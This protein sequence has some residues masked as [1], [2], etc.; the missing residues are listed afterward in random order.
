LADLLELDNGDVLITISDGEPDTTDDSGPA[1]FYAN[2]AERMSPSDL[3]MI[4]WDILEAIEDDDAS[5]SEWL[6]E[7]AKAVEWLGTKLPKQG[8]GKGSRRSRSF[9]TVLLE[10]VLRAHATAYGE[11]LPADGPVKVRDDSEGDLGIYANPIAN[12]LEKD[13]NHFITVTAPEY[14]PDT[15]RMLLWVVANGC[16][17]KKVYRHPVKRRPCS[18]SVDA[19]DLIVSNAATDLAS[20]DRVT[21]RIKMRPA[22]IRRMQRM[23]IYRDVGLSTP[24]FG[25]DRNAMDD[26]KEIASGVKMTGGRPQDFPH[27]VYECYC[28][29]DLVGYE[30]EEDG[31]PTGIPLPYKITIEKDSRE[32]LEIRRNWRDD[33]EM[34]RPIETFVK[35]SYVPMFGFYDIGLTALA[36]NPAVVATALQRIMIDSGSFANFP[37]FLYA[38]SI[39]RQNSLEFDVPPGGGKPIKTDGMPIGDVAMPLPYREP[40]PGIANLLDKVVEQGMRVSGAG[41]VPVDDGRQNAPVGTTLALIEQATKVMSA[42]HKR[43]HAAQAKEF[44]LLKELFREHPE[45]FWRFNRKP[46]TQWTREKLLAALNDNDFVPVADPNTASRTHRIMIA[47]AIWMMATSTPELWNQAAVQ[48]YVLGTLGVE[49]PE[50]LM[51]DPAQDGQDPDPKAMAAALAAQAKMQEA[52]NK[53]EEIKFR[54]ANASIDNENRDLDRESDERVAQINL[55]KEMMIHDKK[56]EADR[57]AQERELVGDLMRQSLDQAHDRNMNG[58]PDDQE[59]RRGEQ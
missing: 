29:Y 16:G 15:D 13:M 44:Q 48:K 32:V 52:Q 1:D 54:A 2:L 19:E 22:M 18:E 23:G 9:H 58:I 59:A 36:G 26:A 6:E 49:N 42:V 45:D 25:P 35:Y 37:G 40:G 39:G 4:A 8:A 38:D 24:T 34:Q 51:A 12:A 30:H 55:A 57:A 7:R 11:L 41:E 47:Q 27:I 50:S 31:E 43:L 10:A 53:A 56:V 46:A 5:R 20:A 28:L 17:F 3:S 14:Y 33:D 21:H